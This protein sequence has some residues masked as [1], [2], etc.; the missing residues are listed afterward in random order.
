MDDI[1]RIH[2]NHKQLDI[3]L[4]KQRHR[5]QCQSVF[6]RPIPDHTHACFTHIHQQI[7]QHPMPIVLDSGCG[8]GLSSRIL[9]ESYPNHWVIA[10]DQ[11]SHRLTNLSH[12]LPRNLLVARDNCVDF[13]RL[14]HA[15]HHHVALHTL[16]YP[17]PW[18]KS[19]H[20]KRRWY[21]HPISPILMAMSPITILRSNWLFYLQKTAIVAQQHGSHTHLKQLKLTSCMAMTH[22]EK[23]YIDHGVDLFELRI[24]A[25]PSL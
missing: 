14:L 6:Q 23:K 5:Q 19:Q 17:N 18:P 22:F 15:S 16:F 21:A 2:T 20:E 13:W 12:T 4:T 10:L 3:P 9:A 11:S 8:K 24:Y 1:Y 25:T 7:T